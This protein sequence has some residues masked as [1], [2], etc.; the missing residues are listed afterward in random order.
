MAILL[1]DGELWETEEKLQLE[2]DD[3]G[4]YSAV[5]EELEEKIEE[6]AAPQ[7]SYDEFWEDF[8][9]Q[10]CPYGNLQD[11]REITR[12]IEEEALEN[13]V[14]AQLTEDKSLL[15]KVAGKVWNYGK[16]VA[17]PAAVGAVLGYLGNG[18]EG[19]QQGAIAGSICVLPWVGLGLVLR[20]NRK[21]PL[22]P[23]GF[24]YKERAIKS[25]K[26]DIEYVEKKGHVPLLFFPL[27]VSGCLALT[28]GLFGLGAGLCAKIGAVDGIL[29]GG[30]S[31]LKGKKYQTLVKKEIQNHPEKYLPNYVPPTME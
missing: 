7:L 29:E 13:V 30:G 2:E 20:N 10:A 18:I 27:I 5:V 11:Q 31:M 24:E 12:K 16:P 25:I 19:A 28:G 15:R 6:Q 22:A 17:R 14:V 8:M 4:V 1:D 21:D 3:P 23:P 26:D 9:Q